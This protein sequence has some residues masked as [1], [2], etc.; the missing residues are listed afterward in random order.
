[1]HGHYLTKIDIDH[2]MKRFYL[3][4]VQPTIL[5]D[6]CLVRTMGRIGR[7]TRILPPLVYQDEAMATTAAERLVARKKRRGYIASG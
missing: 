4:T 3:V 1:M 6:Y 5:G 7:S 2:N